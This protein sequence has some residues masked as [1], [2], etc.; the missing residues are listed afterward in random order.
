[1]TTPNDGDYVHP[2]FVAD[3]SLEIGLVYPGAGKQ[4]PPRIGWRFGRRPADN[5][6][7]G[8]E[9]VEAM[10]KPASISLAN[11]DGQQ[12]GKVQGHLLRNRNDG[13]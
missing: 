5:P 6:N 3:C 2:G 10:L 13:R 8:T 7:I 12:L 11:I 1:M 9:I 4:G